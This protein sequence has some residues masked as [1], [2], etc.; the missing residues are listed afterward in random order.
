MTSCCRTTLLHRLPLL[1]VVLV[2]TATVAVASPAVLSGQV[3]TDRQRPLAGVA[4]KA[5]DGS[6]A[7]TGAD[8]CF[9]L[10]LEFGSNYTVR[11]AKDDYRFVPAEK[12]ITLSCAEMTLDFVASQATAADAAATTE[13][14]FQLSSP[15]AL[16]AKKPA[17]P[18]GQ[19]QPAMVLGP[20]AYEVDDRSYLASWITSGQTQNHTLHVGTDV[21][22]VHFHLDSPSEVRIWTSGAGYLDTVLYLYSDNGTLLQ[23]DDDSGGSLWSLI[24]LTGDDVLP[25]GSYYI[26]VRP[27][28][29]GVGA[30]NLTLETTAVPQP[31]DAYEA[32]DVWSAA[33]P[34]VVGEV[35]NRSIHARYNSDWATFVSNSYATVAVVAEGNVEI[36]LYNSRGGLITYSQGTGWTTEL[37]VMVGPGTYYIRVDGFQR[38]T[39]VEA[40]TLELFMSE[41]IPMDQYEVDDTSASAK[42]ISAGAVQSRTFHTE[43]DCDWAVFTLRQPTPVVIQT[44]SYSDLDS[45]MWLYASNGALVAH[46]DDGGVNRNPLI[47]IDPLAAGTYYVLVRHRGA[48]FTDWPYYQLSLSAPQPDAYESDN[49]SAT[50]STISTK[51]NQLHSIHQYADVDWARF[52]IDEPE[53]IYVRSSGNTRVWLYDIRGALLASNGGDGNEALIGPVSLSPGTYL[54]RVEARDRSRIDQYTLRVMEGDSLR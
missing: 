16:A 43:R 41:Q 35:Q 33:K 11:A 18:T 38:T 52:S 25:T 12:Q 31:L 45:E 10:Q 17:A 6:S 14:L 2:I 50:A 40:Y 15:L 42:T 39:L 34:I 36:S 32:D 54:V 48:S 22:F 1:L 30:Y 9:S 24:E 8:G 27:F 49:T 7:L 21:D 29:L 5:S 46:D 20:D 23:R 51:E 28:H 53:D 47:S 44:T 13:G 3:L 37:Q 26:A 19:V 4:I